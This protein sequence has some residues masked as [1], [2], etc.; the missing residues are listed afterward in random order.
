MSETTTKKTYHATFLLDMRGTQDSVEEV[1]E[2][3]K[4]DVEAVG[5]EVV[6]STNLGAREFART[7]DTGFTEG[8]FIIIELN[9]P[10]TAP[11]ALQERLRLNKVVNRVMVRSKFE[12]TTRR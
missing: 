2:Q 8:P 6:E 5:G 9:G 11:Q 3:L 1:I 12:E 7:P 4:K 10:G